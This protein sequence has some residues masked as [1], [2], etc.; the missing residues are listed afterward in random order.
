MSVGQ[1]G[2]GRLSVAESFARIQARDVVFQKFGGSKATLEYVFDSTA[3]TATRATNDVTI[4]GGDLRLSLPSAGPL[5]PYRF[6]TS[7]PR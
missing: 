1:Y 3:D 7:V 5:N 6:S 2:T 4:N